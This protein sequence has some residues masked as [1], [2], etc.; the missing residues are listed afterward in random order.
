MAI[1][2]R[3]MKLHVDDVIDYH[4]IHEPID[5]TFEDFIQIL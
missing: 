5:P 2:V 3:A 1:T 4:P